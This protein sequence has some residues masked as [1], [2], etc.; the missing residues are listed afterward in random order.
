MYTE[1]MIPTHCT[2]GF[3]PL[4]ALYAPMHMDTARGK[5][6]LARVCIV[7]PDVDRTTIG[8]KTAVVRRNISAHAHAVSV[9]GCL[10]RPWV[11]MY[12]SD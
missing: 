1:L 9:P 8:N 2:C 12:S 5:N 3:F 11:A 4:N 6:V 10:F 7:C